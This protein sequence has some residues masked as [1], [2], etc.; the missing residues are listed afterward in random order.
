[1][2][3]GQVPGLAAAIDFAVKCHLKGI[4][5]PFCIDLLRIGFRRGSAEIVVQ[6]AFALAF[7]FALDRIVLLSP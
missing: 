4:K 7:V 3:K 6:F 2:T 5:L 1:M